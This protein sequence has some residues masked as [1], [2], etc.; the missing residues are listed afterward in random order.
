MDALAE[1]AA[2]AAP[3]APALAGPTRLSA[4]QRWAIIALHKHARWSK[5]RIAR[6]L[7]VSRDT[8]RAVWVRYSLT[9]T[10]ASGSRTGRPPATTSAANDAIELRARTVKFTSPR[11]IAKDL[12]LAVTPFTVRRVLAARNLFGRVARH[13]RDYGAAELRSRLSFANGYAARDADWWSRV[14]FSDEKCFYGRGFNGQQWVIREPGTALDPAHCAH[15]IAR[16]VKVNVWACFSAAG[17][18][19]LHV[20][21]DNMNSDMYRKILD[22]N[23]IDVAARDFPVIGDSVTEWHFL[24]D[25][26]PMHKARIVTEWFH[27]KGVSVLDFPPYSPDLNPIEN[28]WAIMARKVEKMRCDNEE[29]LGDAALKVWNELPQNTFSNLAH[30]MPARCAAV[31]LASGWHTKY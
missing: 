10:P 15:K 5:R 29:S 1:L 13:K 25:N 17:P 28:L 27:N 20:F 6:E 14:Y 24:Q 4:E 23:L 3:A 26:A 30:S 12:E 31:V 7:G 8:V 18:G 22:D 16:P 21:Y 19:F 2:A 11:Q 9:G